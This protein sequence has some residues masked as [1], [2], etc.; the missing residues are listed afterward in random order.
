MIG[1]EIVK[2]IAREP[3]GQRDQND[4]RV[5]QFIRERLRSSRE[6]LLNTAYVEVMRNDTKVENYFAEEVLKASK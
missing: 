3:S 2:L 5:Q 6:Q 4:P 1:F